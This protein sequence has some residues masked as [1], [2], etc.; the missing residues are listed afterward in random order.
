MR[1]SVS[2]LLPICQLV[3]GFSNQASVQSLHSPVTP[4]R[5]MPTGDSFTR[6]SKHIT[7]PLFGVGAPGSNTKKKRISRAEAEQ[8]R[9]EAERASL[10]VREQ[11]EPENYGGESDF[12]DPPSRSHLPS[13]PHRTTANY[14]QPSGHERPETY[15]IHAIYN[16]GITAR[17]RQNSPNI[18]YYSRDGV[19]LGQTVE[20]PIRQG[21]ATTYPVIGVYDDGTLRQRQG[22]HLIH[23]VSWQ[24]DLQ[25]SEQLP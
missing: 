14:P 8:Q 11:R 10:Q 12:S 13:R 19:Y 1:F 18:Y 5:L 15:P 21:E 4:H 23:Y 24:G 22:S 7:Q 16:Q 20:Q 6:S 2:N 17:Q 3:P 25:F 9:L